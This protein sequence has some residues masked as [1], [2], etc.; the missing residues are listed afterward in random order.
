MDLGQY[1]TEDLILTALKAE[2]EKVREQVQN[3]E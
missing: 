1:S 2:V 3:L